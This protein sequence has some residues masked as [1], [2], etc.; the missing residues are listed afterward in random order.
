MVWLDHVHIGFNDYSFLKQQDKRPTIILEPAFPLSYFN[1][2]NARPGDL[3]MSYKATS[4]CRQSTNDLYIYQ[5]QICQLDIPLLCS[6][7]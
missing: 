1:S 6:A 3:P 5:E 4:Q 2:S 7:I